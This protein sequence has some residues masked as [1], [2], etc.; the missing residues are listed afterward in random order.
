M[1]I[2]K[3]KKRYWWLPFVLVLVN[4]S[5]VYAQYSPVL[6]IQNPELAEWYLHD[7]TLYTSDGQCIPNAAIWIKR[8]LIKQAGKAPQTPPKGARSMSLSGASVYPSFIDL[9]GRAGMPEEVKSK[10]R[11]GQ[12][13]G[14]RELSSYYWNDAIRT[15]QHAIQVLPPQLSIQEEWLSAGFGMALV[16]IPDGVDRGTGAFIY[17]SPLHHGSYVINGRAS[18]HYSLEKGSSEMAFPSSQTG[19]IALLRQWFIDLNH[20]K[21][22]EK[23]KKANPLMDAAWASYSLPSF[24][25]VKGIWEA[26]KVFHLGSKEF[27]IGDLIVLGDGKEYQRV[28][29]I[30]K[31]GVRLLLPLDL[32]KPP[33]V[34]DP[35]IAESVEL[36]DLM[37]WEAAPFNISILE[38]EGVVYALSSPKKA[39]DFLDNLRKVQQ[40]G[41][42]ST[43]LLQSLTSVPAQW[44]KSDNLGNIEKGKGANLVVFSG[45][46]FGKKKPNVLAH[47][48]HGEW[49]YQSSFPQSPAGFADIRGTWTSRSD[50]YMALNN[51]SM[52]WEGEWQK[53]Q[54]KYLG[55]SETDKQTM[56]LQMDKYGVTF[57]FHHTGVTGALRFSG[58]FSEPDLIVGTLFLPQG[59][60]YG[61]QWQRKKPMEGSPEAS[62][63]SSARS[64][65]IPEVRVPMH[66]YGFHRDSLPLR[67]SF[68]VRNATVYTGE[69]VGILKETDVWVQNGKIHQIGKK[70]EVPSQVSEINGSQCFLTAGIIDEHSH[71]A[72][73]KGVNESGLSI[74]SMVRMGDVINPDDP[75][76]YHQLSGGVTAA[77]LLHGSANVIGGQ[78]ALIKLA[79]GESADK[80][81]IPNAPGFIKFALGENVKQSNWGESFTERYPQ[82]RMGVEAFLRD[83]FDRALEYNASKSQPGFR[84]DLALE[85]ISEILAGNRHITCHSYVRSEILMLMQLTRSYGI[86]VN[87]FTH[88]LEGYKVAREMAEHGTAGSTFSDWWAYKMEVMDAIPYNA[89]CMHR[90]GVLVAINS[91]DASMG[92]RL[93]QEAA[94]AIK[95]GRISKEEA[96]A[97]VTINPAK[98]LHLD[99][100]MGSIVQGKDAD[101]VLWSHD[102][103]TMKARVLYTWVDGV[104]RYSKSN[105]DYLA[106]RAV[107]RKVELTSKAL[108]E[109]DK[110]SGVSSDTPTSGAHFH[111]ETLGY[112]D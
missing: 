106:E 69:S 84:R 41:A 50:T 102:P 11:A 39:S 109:I 103:L 55:V 71:I 75:H 43:R 61:L 17:L 30:Q 7:L 44:I 80:M 47:M 35:Y 87:T 1:N 73:R 100:R 10:R 56:K 79:W 3:V 91:D 88:I 27:N 22:L 67:K 45:S 92:R 95:Y 60:S 8:G 59:E 74:S 52:T 25:H 105:D 46:L 19:S 70:L 89:A 93:N 90:S 111:C 2:N 12:Y 94:K 58:S 54:G 112:D 4:P 86:K 82:T 15:E 81:L 9:N 62:K 78:S 76:I 5:C 98:M 96:W 6:E 34:K 53:P 83:I 63:S 107:K 31:S 21:S 23:G 13:S 104:L 77:Q 33:D 29:L 36:V 20:Y 28:S 64:N 108:L 66:P 32:P 65:V 18:R 49:V 85:A 16:H 72:L 24:F 57:S 68:V 14:S 110:G 48:L 26:L 37:H 38:K 51:K 101:I 40:S 99:S 42:D 97:M